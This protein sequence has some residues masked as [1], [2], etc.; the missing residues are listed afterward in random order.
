MPSFGNKRVYARDVVVAR[1]QRPFKRGKFGRGVQKLNKAVTFKTS[2][3][4]N[5]SLQNQLNALK[6]YVNSTAPELK[7]RDTAITIA[8]L[9]NPGSAVHITSIPQGA[10]DSDR[11]GDSVKL[12]SI[13]LKG[14]INSEVYAGFAPDTMIRFAL[15]RWKHQANQDNTIQLTEVFGPYDVYNLERNEGH[16][17]HFDVMW[18]SKIFYARRFQQ[19]A[20][21]VPT[22][23]PVIEEMFNVDIDVRFH[24]STSSDIAGNGLYFI[25]L[26]SDTTGSGIIDFVGNARMTFID[27]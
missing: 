25:G 4:K 14:K 12:K 27:T 10:S 2:I 8:N 24:G 17:D 26:T 22:E 20:G 21:F 6:K 23:T 15:V 9:T 11:I 7:K 3:S 19:G 1:P 13:S 16:I 5:I 18:V